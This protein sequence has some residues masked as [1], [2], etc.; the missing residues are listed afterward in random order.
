[1]GRICEVKGNYVGG[2]CGE[3]RGKA[4]HGGCAKVRGNC[5]RKM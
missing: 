5:G 4:V 3:V 2:V 1:M